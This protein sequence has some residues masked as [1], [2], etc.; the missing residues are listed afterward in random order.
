MRVTETMIFQRTTDRANAALVNVAKAQSQV[1]SGLRVVAP[2]DDPQAAGMLVRHR[3]DQTRI[4]AIQSG[5]QRAL[6]ELNASDSALEGVKSSLARAQVLA[7]QFGNDTYS[8]ADRAS[9]AEEVDGLFKQVMGDLNTRFGDRYLFGGFKDNQPPFDASGGYNGD[10]GVR[11]VEVAP[12]VYDDASVR[13]DLMAKGVG[14]G[15][16]ILQGLQDL[17]TAL[18][19]NDGDSIRASIDNLQTGLDQVSAARSRVGTS[20]NI[21]TSTVNECSL[22][23][24][25]KKKVISELGDADV[26]D[27]SSKL[28]LAQYA[29]NATLTAASKTLDFSLVNLLK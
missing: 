25:D 3:F 9:A 24:L 20:V 8:A 21:F 11:Q 15:V 1:S 10:T 7:T 2:G 18:R 29:L 16:D 22:Q 26:L 19:S 12:G 4:T 14:G 17:S 23:I 13:A 28:S 27:A 5:A 6:D